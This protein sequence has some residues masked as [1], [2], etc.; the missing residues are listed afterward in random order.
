[1]ED[2]VDNEVVGVPSA[3]DTG[4]SIEKAP[5]YEVTEAPFRYYRKLLEKADAEICRLRRQLDL[6]ARE[7]AR[8]AELRADGAAPDRAPEKATGGSHLLVRQASPSG[9]STR[10]ESPTMGRHRSQCVPIWTLQSKQVPAGASPGRASSLSGTARR[11]PLSHRSWDA[12]GRT[13]RSSPQPQR[14][15]QSPSTISALTSQLGTLAVGRKPMRSPPASTLARE[16]SPTGD[17]RARRP[18]VGRSPSRGTQATA[19]A[20]T[21]LRGCSV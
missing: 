2:L 4:G 19:S 17:L 5:Q 18:P 11:S 9:R 16:E 10:A 20:G 13:G 6:K 12:A 3:Q 15:A 8:L 14:R 7:E 21:L 1:M